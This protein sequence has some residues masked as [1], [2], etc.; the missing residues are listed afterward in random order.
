ME[1]RADLPA[2]AVDMGGTM[3]KVGLIEDRSVTGRA[4]V[5][6]KSR[7]GVVATL[8]EIEPAIARLHTGGF[9]AVGIAFPGIV[10][11]TRRAVIATN[12]KY[13]DG[14]RFDF[15]A[16]ARESWDCPCVMDNDARLASVGEWKYGAGR[17]VSNL[18]A[19][20]LGTGFGAS[21]IIG[22]RIL[23]GAHH[24]AGVL[25]GHISVDFLG[26]RCSCGNVGCAEA[27]ASTATLDEVIGDVLGEAPPARFRD[28]DGVLG[29]QSLFALM[30]DGDDQARRVIEFCV[31]VWGQAI[32]NLIHA[33]DPERVVVGGG[34][35][36]RWD[37][38]GPALQAI[39]DDRAWLPSSP[40]EIARATRP[41]DAA[42]LGL[43][44]LM[45]Q[46]DHSYEPI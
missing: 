13:D 23:R 28:E 15:D 6:A 44:W 12:A 4:D 40:I 1:S 22:G 14:R 38:L 3:V 24:Q 16:W 11:P 18:V 17:G 39:V 31:G 7:H 27:T 34:V 29:F 37:Y 21:A 19:V 9:R 25:G 42:L 2:L 43:M 46:G 26:R 5:P 8:K 35:T 32:V 30:D 33:Y 45:N 36:A 41:D 10:D 20:T